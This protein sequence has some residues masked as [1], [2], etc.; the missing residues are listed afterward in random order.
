MECFFGFKFKQIEKAQL[1]IRFL[2]RCAFPI[3]Q[4]P[5]MNQ[6]DSSTEQLAEPQQSLGLQPPT[7]A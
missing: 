3:E 6:P 7:K 1:V 5:F 4:H 2:I